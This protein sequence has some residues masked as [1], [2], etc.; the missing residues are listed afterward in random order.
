MKSNPNVAIT[1]VFSICTGMLIC[2]LAVALVATPATGHG[3]FK[4]TLEKKYK[5]EGLRVTCN[6]CHVKGEEKTQRNEV[7]QIFF[8]EFEGQD[9]SA[10]WDAVEGD[11]RKKLEKEVMAPE[12]LKAL[13]K[14]YKQEADGEIEST[15]ATQIPGGEVEGT[16]LKKRKK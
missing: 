13:D 11:E 7:G 6:M 3:I 14:I 9:L 10:K 16:K 5:E 4:K 8:K 2:G 1:R 15:Y 12:F